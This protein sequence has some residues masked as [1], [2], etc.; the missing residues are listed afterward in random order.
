MAAPPNTITQSVTAAVTS[1]PHEA[2]KVTQPTKIAL[3]V[4]SATA[5]MPDHKTGYFWAELLH[6]YEVFTK[7]GYDVDIFSETGIATVDESSI[8]AMASGGDK[9]KYED[10]QFPL[11]AKIAAMRAATSAD[12]QQYSAIY[13]AGGHAACI[14]FPKATNLQSLAARIYEHGGTVGADCH[15]PA[16]FEGLKL[17]NGD[18]LLK[19]KRATGFAT[20]AEETMK[21]MD[22][23]RQHNLKTMKEIV[24]GCGGEWH[25]HKSNPMAEYTEVS[26]RVVTGMNPAS[27]TAVAEA[28]LTFQ[29]N[30]HK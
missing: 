4:S 6:P 23:M 2:P 18:F 22:W 12:P 14:D 15:G 25:E 26:D 30:A 29:P 28:M 5:Q 24:E 10:K 8:G 1:V 21:V 20:S 7:A 27:A 19:G 9:K 13:F 3:A 17:S 16:I 11:H